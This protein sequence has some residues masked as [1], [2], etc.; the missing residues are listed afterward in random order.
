VID[1]INR[2][3]MLATLFAFL[4]LLFAPLLFWLVEHNRSADVHSV[5]D[6]YGWLFR[7]LF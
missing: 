4:V 6:S 7:T 1:R 2:R 3:L 5:G